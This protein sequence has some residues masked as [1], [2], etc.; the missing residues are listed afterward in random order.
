MSEMHDI[1]VSSTEKIMR[2]LSTKELVDLSEKGKFASPLWETLLESGLT[3]VGIP[4]SLNG[5]DGDL[6]DALEI[7]KLAGKYTLPLPLFE[8]L[9]VQWLLENEEVGSYDGPFTF[10]LNSGLDLKI[11]NNNGELV[12][13]G[14]LHNVPWARYSTHVLTMEDVGGESYALLIPMNGAEVVNYSNVA[15]EPS[16][17]VIFNQF[18]VENPI[19]VKVEKEKFLT[20]AK[21][22]GALGKAAMMTGA[23]EGVMSLTLDYVQ[24]RE[25]FGRPLYRFQAI[26]QY[27]ATLAGEVVLT[28]TLLNQSISKVNQDS[29]SSLV[30]AL[31]IQAN[32]SVKIVNELAHQIHGAIGV[33]HEHKL[34]QFT[35]RLWAWR[36]EFGN[37]LEW[38]KFLANDLLSNSQD[39]WETITESKVKEF[40]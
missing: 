29:D 6:H 33:T 36:E 31:K 10:S 39:L 17:R 2:D 22:L 34:H 3:K 24:E 25:Q 12:I 16:D 23:M 8:T 14:E 38:S 4:E 1:I 11:S 15:G 30:S 7:L 40:V 32:S 9:L 28:N 13:D 27:M 18:V 37:E 21:T 26:Q 20:Q 19:R 35:R 5:S